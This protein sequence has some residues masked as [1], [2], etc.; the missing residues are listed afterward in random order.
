MN[1]GAYNVVKLSL[2]QG[3]EKISSKKKDANS[4]RKSCRVPYTHLCNIYIQWPTLLVVFL[5][6]NSI[7]PTLAKPQTMKVYLLTMYPLMQIYALCVC[8]GVQQHGYSVPAGTPI[9]VLGAV[10]RSK[11]Y[12]TH[13]LFAELPLSTDSKYLFNFFLHLY[14]FFI[15]RYIQLYLDTFIYV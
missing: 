9:V 12:N 15:I 6:F 10:R 3:S 1:W 7:P 11:S 2:S 4:T 13:A 14:P 8:V 5:M